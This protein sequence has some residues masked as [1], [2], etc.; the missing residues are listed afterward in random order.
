MSMAWLHVSAAADSQS[1]TPPAQTP[2]AAK[3]PPPTATPPTHKKPRAAIPP[4]A[5]ALPR[6]PHQPQPK[7]V[8]L[9]SVVAVSTKLR[10]MS[11]KPL[12]TSEESRETYH[13]AYRARAGTY[14]LLF[15]RPVTAAKP[16]ID[17]DIGCTWVLGSGGW[18]GGKAAPT[19]T[20][21]PRPTTHDLLLL[22]AVA[23]LQLI[24]KTASR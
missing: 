19:P 13:S 9:F 24:A 8:I 20:Q 12:R 14:R 5:P 7:R 16:Y 6:I 2:R 10:L 21:S 23:R 15:R 11:R 4:G 3:Q 18:G 17:I 22:G 1:S